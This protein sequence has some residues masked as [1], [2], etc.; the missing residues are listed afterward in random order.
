MR[1]YKAYI[2]SLEGVNKVLSVV[3]LRRV[4]TTRLPSKSES[5]P[6]AVLG[7]PVAFFGSLGALFSRLADAE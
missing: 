6:I 4:R 7:V 1:H 3:S 2:I 5:S